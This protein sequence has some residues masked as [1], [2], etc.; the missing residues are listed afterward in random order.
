[1][2]I[3]STAEKR[4]VQQDMLN[5]GGR[6]YGVIEIGLFGGKG[7]AVVYDGNGFDI[8]SK[9]DAELKQLQAEGYA[10]LSPGWETKIE[11][12]R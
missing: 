7:E 4:K 11:K 5:G 2:P 8:G 9:S 10:V 1:V 12:L 6:F 3:A